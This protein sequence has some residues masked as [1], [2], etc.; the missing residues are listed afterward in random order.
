MYVNILVDRIVHRPPHHCVFCYRLAHSLALLFVV[1]A[2]LGVLA[3]PVPYVSVSL[4]SESNFGTVNEFFVLQFF[5]DEFFFF[6]IFFLASFLCVCV[7]VQEK[8]KKKKKKSEQRTPG[9][10]NR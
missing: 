10:R 9:Q 8:K 3:Q 4:P 2:Q 6:F 1:A 5:L 7:C